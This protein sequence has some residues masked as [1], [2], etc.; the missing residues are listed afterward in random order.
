[1]FYLHVSHLH[2]HTHT[3]THSTL[4]LAH[5]YAPVDK[6]VADSAEYQTMIHCTVQLKTAVSKTLS[7]LGGYLLA[8]GLIARN[9]AC[10]LRNGTVSEDERAATLVELVQNKV[11]LDPQNYIKFISI[12]QEDGEYYNEILRSLSEVYRLKGMSTM[13]IILLWGGR[14]L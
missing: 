11:K 5:N 7:E 13:Y 1:M 9:N 8:G 12:L 14:I 2:T 4:A 3:H 10:E 6:G